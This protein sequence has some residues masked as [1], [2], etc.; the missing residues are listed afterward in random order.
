MGGQVLKQSTARRLEL[1]DAEEAGV[2]EA[3]SRWG[4]RLRVSFVTTGRRSKS[5]TRHWMVDDEQGRRVVDFWPT[6]GNWWC[7]ATGET[8]EC[9][10]PAEIVEAARRLAVRA[11]GR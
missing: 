8:G 6:K 9:D 3:L 1:I 11:C 7:R 2:R 10:E 4:L 5:E